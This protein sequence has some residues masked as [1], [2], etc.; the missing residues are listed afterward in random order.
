MKFLLV[1]IKVVDAPVKTSNFELKTGEFSIFV[2][3]RLNLFYFCHGGA[4]LG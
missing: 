3:I 2:I 4:L 1:V